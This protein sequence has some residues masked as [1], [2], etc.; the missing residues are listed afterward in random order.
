[1]I[2]EVSTPEDKPVKVT[3]APK[4]VRLVLEVPNRPARVVAVLR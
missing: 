1:M 4:E 3:G 2:S